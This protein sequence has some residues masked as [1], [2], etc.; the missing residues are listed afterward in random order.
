MRT[1]FKLFFE[2]HFDS[3]SIS[4]IS[5]DLVKGD[6]L[7]LVIRIKYIITSTPRKVLS[8]TKKLERRK[9]TYYA[10]FYLSLKIISLVF[11]CFKFY[12]WFIENWPMWYLRVLLNLNLIIKRNSWRQSRWK[13]F[14]KQNFKI[15]Q[16]SSQ[17]RIRRD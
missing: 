7:R 8:L 14:L 6:L 9:E 10:L 1:E 4:N 15:S 3:P 17:F 5:S 13:L 2:K 11:R 16:N 12:M